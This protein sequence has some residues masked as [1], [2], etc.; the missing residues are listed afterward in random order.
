VLAHVLLLVLVHL[1]PV[2][3]DLLV[4]YLLA[5]QLLVL[6][7]VVLL[8][9]HLLVRQMLRRFRLVVDVGFANARHRGALGDAAAALH[10]RAVLPL[11]VRVGHA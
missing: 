9:R 4:Y 6:L 8:V 1:V 11:V 2:R 5:R 10:L 7:L 3:I